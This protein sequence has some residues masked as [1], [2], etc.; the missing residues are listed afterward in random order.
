MEHAKLWKRILNEGITQFPPFE[1]N[2]LV[3]QI[4]KATLIVFP[5]RDDRDLIEMEALSGMPMPMPMATRPVDLSTYKFCCIPAESCWIERVHINPERNISIG[6]LFD[7][8]QTKT[9]HD[10]N[11]W[12][13]SERAGGPGN[14]VLNGRYSIKLDKNGSYEA[15]SVSY[16][17]PDRSEEFHKF[18]YGPQAT[19]P[20]HAI[21]ATKRFGGSPEHYRYH[22]LE[23]VP[24]NSKPGTRGVPI[25]AMPR[26]FCRGHF[27]EYGPEF[28][29][30]LLFGKYSGRFY[31]PP[32]FKGDNKNG[33]V[34]KDYEIR[35]PLP[36][37]I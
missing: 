29:K 15:N 6:Q 35:S 18:H 23:I 1:E 20:E 11:F 16:L 32:C 27:A 31:V 34:E 12:E 14:P 22:T 10:V 25:G 7:S 8:R 4:I 5:D 37:V 17:V 24:N 2:Q 9:G 19:E 36:A 13:I 3:A 26:H 33:I 21:R 30:G 28:N